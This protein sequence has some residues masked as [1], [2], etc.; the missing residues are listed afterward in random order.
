MRRFRPRSRSRPGTTLMVV[1]VLLVGLVG[2]MSLAIDVGYIAHTRT[3]L[4]R[5]ADAG[6]LAGVVPLAVSGAN[7][8]DLAAARAEAR[9]FVRFNEGSDNFAVPD[10]DILF[11]RYDPAK[12][13]GTRFTPGLKGGPV[14]ALRV[15]VRRDGAANGSLRLF[16]G[17][18]IGRASS[19][20]RAVAT[21]HLPP[22]GG[23][24]PGPDFL[25]Y[26]IQVDYFN[27]AVGLPP[28]AGAEAVPTE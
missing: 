26:A 7:A 5:S 20:V 17:Q 8:Q 16:F 12:S 6:A 22:G 21:V 11:G 19:D 13:A 14:T 1:T 25:P 27:K 9:R 4:Q 24:R 15:T 28:R 10:D 23:V 2:M 3:A 18:V